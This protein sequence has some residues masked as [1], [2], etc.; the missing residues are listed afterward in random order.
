M[1]VQADNNTVLDVLVELYEGDTKIED[2]RLNF[3]LATSQDELKFELT[4]FLDT[5]NSE[6]NQAEVNAEQEAAH[7]QADETI[8]ALEGFTVGDGAEV[9]AEESVSV[10]DEVSAEVTPEAPAAT[11]GEAG[12]NVDAGN[13]E[14][15]NEEEV[16]S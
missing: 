16:Q 15:V 8:A 6:R 7:A 10:T 3:P 4:K 9:S 14:V 12:A 2:R 5:Y 13:P 11:E 1:D